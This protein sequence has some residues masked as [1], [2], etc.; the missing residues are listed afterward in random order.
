MVIRRNTWILMAIFAILSGLTLYLQQNQKLDPESAYTPV[1]T[2]EVMIGQGAQI[3]SLEMK[4]ASGGEMK[5]ST[6]SDGLWKVELPAG[7]NADQGTIE[8]M[9]SQMEAIP[10]LS[11][12]STPPPPDATGL[13]QPEYTLIL[14]LKDGQTLTWMIGSET[15]T[16]NGRYTQ[17]SGRPVQVVSDYSLESLLNLFKSLT[18]PT[19]TPTLPETPTIVSQTQV[20]PGQGEGASLTPK[21]G[22]GTST[23]E[24]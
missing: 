17:I 8:E 20:A 15:V 10:S 22:T 12:L 1:P 16:Q 23:S 21:P 2:K 11:T 13:S 5:I 19:L 24:P 7:A 9:I 14:N 6:G 18:T 3:T 4:A